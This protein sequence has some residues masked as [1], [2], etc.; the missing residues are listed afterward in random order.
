[1]CQ[2]QPRCPTT[3][4]G[5]QVTVGGRAVQARQNREYL[6]RLLS[7]KQPGFLSTLRSAERRVGFELSHGSLELS[8]ESRERRRA[9]GPGKSSSR[10][11][12]TSKPNEN[13][14][15]HSRLKSSGPE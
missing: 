8:H 12:Q 6:R 9:P 4:R 7:E 14:G 10:S 11:D 2:R 1:M 15:Q 3:G 13:L 5:R